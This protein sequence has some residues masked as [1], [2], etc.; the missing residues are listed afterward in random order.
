MITGK[1]LR[2]YVRDGEH[3]YVHN[4]EWMCMVQWYT[5]LLTTVRKSPTL[6]G[7]FMFSKLGPR[8]GE[9]GPLEKYK[10]MNSVG[11]FVDWLRNY[12]YAKFTS[13]GTRNILKLVAIWKIHNVLQVI[14]A[15]LLK[16]DNVYIVPLDRKEY[17]G[18]SIFRSL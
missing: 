2:S 18:Y 10:L 13:L 8:Q 7:N 16:R 5:V 15:N 6:N 4:S 12:F 14:S 3:P 11:A 9:Q 1:L 17:F